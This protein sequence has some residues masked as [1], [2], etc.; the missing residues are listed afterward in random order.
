[1]KR[2]LRYILLFLLAAGLPAAAALKNSSKTDA[3]FDRALWCAFSVSQDG[4]KIAY[5][6]PA[7]DD[8][9]DAGSEIWVSKID[10]SQRKRLGNLPGFWNVSWCGSD[11]VACSQ[12][13]VNTIPVF[14]VKTGK[15]RTLSL[16]EHYY[17]MQPAV[18][19]NCKW[20]VFPAVQKE[21]R[22]SGVFALDAVSGKIK[23]LTSDVVKSFVD[24]S[25][26]SKR[27]AYGIGQYERHY[28][29]VVCDVATGKVT[30]TGLDGVGAVW[31]PDGKSL[32]YVGNVVKGGSWMGGIPCDGSIMITN[33]E[34]KAGRSLT[35]PGSNVY[36]KTTKHWEISGALGPQWSRDGRRIAYRRYHHIS[37]GDKD[38][39][40][41]DEIWVVNVDGS[42]RKKV[43][44]KWSAFVWSPDNK[45]ILVKTANGITRVAVDSGKQSSIVAWK[46]PALPKSANEA[47]RTI[48]ALGATVEYTLVKPAYAEAI[49]AAASE[50]RRIYAD[51][52]HFSMP[53][54]IH[55]K[56][57]K[58]SSRKAQ[59]WTDGEDHMFLTISSNDDLKPPMQSGVFNIYGICHELGHIAMYRNINMIGLPDGVGE[60]W[61]YYAGSVVV[62]ELYKKLGKSLWPDHYDYSQSE[63]LTRLA[64]D[65]KNP[66]ASKSASTRAALVFYNAQQRYGVDKVMAAMI[67]AEEGK[68]YGKDIMKR[69]ADAL[70]KATGDE[71]ARVLIPSDLLV[72]KVKWNVKEREITDKTV[73]GVEQVKD[74]TGILLKYDDG[75]S[76][77]KWSTAG[78]GQAV[79][80]KTP[81]GSWA[82]DSVQIYASRYGQE[83]APDEDFHVYI[84]DKDFEVIKD[85]AKPYSIFERTEGPKWYTIDFPPVKVSDGFYVCFSFNP[86]AEKGV[87]VYTDKNYKVRPHSKYAMPWSFVNDVGD[88][89]YFDWMIRAHLVAQR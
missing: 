43:F 79:V 56:I 58:S 71:S 89:G 11:Q 64:R 31:S 16:S 69:F 74:D 82:V 51:K 54:V 12:F 45:A 9:G 40:Q 53:A 50:A 70:V 77:G 35:E 76:D 18:S 32:A 20:V 8:Y 39:L 14:S 15:R 73:E 4:S 5:I 27:V 59:L 6:A 81:P 60:G 83:K 1:M 37:E 44:D 23:R 24:W 85:I 28:K 2:Y 66:E 36:D 42:G 49:L 65:A 34:S 33:L 26:D 62:D 17:W 47:A 29:L 52:F 38:T 75:S 78:S 7:Y 80:F 19:P 68:P 67:A 84:C 13:D 10:G 63:G 86:T 30:D 46:T 72:A 55:V 25:P 88:D 22:E 3:A 48:Q 61:A 87:Y 41:E 21:P 57:D